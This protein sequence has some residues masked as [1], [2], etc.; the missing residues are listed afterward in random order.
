MIV[1]LD[2][3]TITSALVDMQAAIPEDSSVLSDEDGDFNCSP[4]TQQTS[5]SPSCVD[6]PAAPATVSGNLSKRGRRSSVLRGAALPGH[7]L[8]SSHVHTSRSLLLAKMS[9]ARRK[10]GIS[11]FCTNRFPAWL[12]LAAILVVLPYLV[13]PV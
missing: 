2:I 13:N 10:E 3:A 9:K 12:A 1:R 6:S 8:F 11:H 7:L 5:C 4:S